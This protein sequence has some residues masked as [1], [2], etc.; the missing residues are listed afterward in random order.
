MKSLIHNIFNH[1]GCIERETLLKYQK[2]LL[3]RE[4][5]HEVE[6]HLTDCELCS[7]SLEGLAL[8]SSNSILDELDQ[9]LNSTL[10]SKKYSGSR[11][12]SRVLWIAA[13][14]SVMF[15]L[16]VFAWY[17]FKSAKDGDRIM[18]LNSS[19]ELHPAT[20]YDSLQSVT[21]PVESNGETP[22]LT[23]SSQNVQN[24][25]LPLN[26]VPEKRESES[27]ANKSLDDNSHE[28]IAEAEVDDEMILEEATIAEP[29][30]VVAEV[31]P[32][33]TPA[34]S[35]ATGNNLQ[36]T[37]AAT[38]IPQ[39]TYVNGLKLAVNQSDSKPLKKQKE[40]TSK[41]VSP[42]YENKDAA[43]KAEEPPVVEEELGYVD[44]ITPALNDFK[45]A[46]YPEAI[47][48][49][50]QISAFYPNDE[51]SNFYSGLAY[52]NSNDFEA[53]IEHLEP[54]AKSSN[55]VFKEE[56]EYYIALSYY[57]SGKKEKGAKLLKKIVADKG[58]YADQATKFLNN[59]E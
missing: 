12:P 11:Q 31:T 29:D 5:Q 40:V 58:F 25:K 51:S 59:P 34:M 19:K 48:K 7:E 47:Q 41:S 26:Q 38:S 4:Q 6:L 32:S 10:S 36:F 52:Y 50:D 23:E 43:A 9:E 20:S 35:G 28:I 55:G 42:K 53:A 56:A 33:K 2:G 44:A 22:E 17:Q 1:T 57:K 24:E 27:V 54:L 14:I 46:E 13:S 45:N 49:L 30:Q 16:S 21:S 18:S 3:S 39:I 8:I 15:L 37:G